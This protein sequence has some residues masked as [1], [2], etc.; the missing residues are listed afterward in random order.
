MGWE[1]AVIAGETSSIRE[2]G[3]ATALKLSGRADAAGFPPEF[4]WEKAA[5]IE[6]R[7]D[8]QGKNADP[9]R[10]TEVRILWTADVLYLRFLAK[11]RSIT[12][13]EDAE[14]GGRRDK[15]WERDVAEVFLQ[16]EGSERHSYKEIEVSPNGMWIDL[17]I[18]PEG[19]RDLRSGLKRRVHVDEKMTWRAELAVPMESLIGKFDPAAAWRVN[20]YRV[21]G[22]TEPRFY[23]AWRPTGTPEP[24]FHVPEAFGKLVFER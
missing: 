20:F 18:A 12:V 16:P 8:W 21:E 24:N 5:A 13:F 6:F 1:Q 2:T 14:P 3:T 23:S 4:A 22:A 17:D 15:L 10:E 9:Q 11:Y 19:K 7:H